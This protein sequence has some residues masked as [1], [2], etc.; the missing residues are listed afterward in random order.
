MTHP[1]PWQ[2]S[3]ELELGLDSNY[4]TSNPEEVTENYLSGLALLWDK[5]KDTLTVVT[6][7]M[8]WFCDCDK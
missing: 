1:L 8:K 5:D 3:T 7:Q 2:Q 6:M 4:V